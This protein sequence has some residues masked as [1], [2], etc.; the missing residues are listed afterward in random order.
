M[1]DRMNLCDDKKNLFMARV[2][3]YAQQTIHKLVVL[4]GFKNCELSNPAVS[5]LITSL[6]LFTCSGLAERLETKT[7]QS[8][9]ATAMIASF[10]YS[11][12]VQYMNHFI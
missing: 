2:I 10:I 1:Q 9:W 12:T 5:F 7:Q 11:F 4:H 6:A 3:K 8:I